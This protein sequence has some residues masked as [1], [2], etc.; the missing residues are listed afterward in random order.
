MFFVLFLI[1]KCFV[2]ISFACH[3]FP[4]G[5]VYNMRFETAKLKYFNS[6]SY[7]NSF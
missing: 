7:S 5:I 1:L 3:F 4:T 2:L 6:Y